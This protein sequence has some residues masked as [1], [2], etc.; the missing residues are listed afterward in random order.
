MQLSDTLKVK[1]QRTETG[2]AKQTHF[3]LSDGAVSSGTVTSAG[4]I[5]KAVEAWEEK[6]FIFLV[7]LVATLSRIS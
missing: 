7:G 4:D 1:L 6:I 5:L 3:L 2:L